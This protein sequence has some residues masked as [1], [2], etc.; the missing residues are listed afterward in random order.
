MI[1]AT[2][3]TTCFAI[4]I[5]DSG[6]YFSLFGCLWCSEHSG[7]C[8]SILSDVT[9]HI[10]VPVLAHIVSDGFQYCMVA[11]LII[12]RFLAAPKPDVRR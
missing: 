12:C 6:H 4:P 11:F 7:L 10:A 3:A 5:K 8:Q 2:L 9:L 1:G